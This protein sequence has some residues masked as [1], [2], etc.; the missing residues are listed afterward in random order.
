MVEYLSGSKDLFHGNHLVITHSPLRLSIQE[1]ECV[2]K[3]DT[4]NGL[5][6]IM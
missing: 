1:W 4:V 2:L 5:K 3:N 6:Q